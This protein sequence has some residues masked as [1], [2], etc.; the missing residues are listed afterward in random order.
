MRRDIKVCYNALTQPPILSGTGNEY[1]PK[2]DDALPLGSKSRRGSIHFAWGSSR[3]NVYWSRP[4]VSV[5]LSL[6]VFPHYCTDPD[7]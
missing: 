3:R 1:R 6:A 2:Y 5:C 4:S 7:L